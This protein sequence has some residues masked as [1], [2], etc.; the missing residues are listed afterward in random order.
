MSG[1]ED[2]GEGD[3]SI[4]FINIGRGDKIFKEYGQKI[5]SGGMDD[6]NILTFFMLLARQK[7]PL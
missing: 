1:S 3:N 7:M 2:R 5:G 6:N 4:Q